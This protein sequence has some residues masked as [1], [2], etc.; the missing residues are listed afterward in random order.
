MHHAYAEGTLIR[1]DDEGPIWTIKG[2]KR[3]RIP[4]WDV[5]LQSGYKVV[6]VLKLSEK[7]LSRIP[8][9]P[10]STEFPVA[11]ALVRILGDAS[12]PIWLVEHGIRRRIPD[13]ETFKRLGYSLEYVQHLGRKIVGR[14]PEGDPLASSRES[15]EGVASA[16]IQ[17]APGSNAVGTSGVS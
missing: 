11:S 17:I 8:E 15:S 7:T 13:W 3:R 6:D 4:G 12:G 10:I 2:G 5:F 14:L 16:S 9:G 1:C